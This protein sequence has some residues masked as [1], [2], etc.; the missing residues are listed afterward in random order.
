[1][2]GKMLIKVTL[3]QALDPELYERLLQFDNA[4]LRASAFRALASAAAKGDGRRLDLDPVRKSTNGAP[5]T[6]AITAAPTGSAQSPAKPVNDVDPLANVAPGFRTGDIA[7]Q[8]H[9]W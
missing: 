2:N 4:R 7:E 9:N 6:E 3:N 5:S 8:F 1:M